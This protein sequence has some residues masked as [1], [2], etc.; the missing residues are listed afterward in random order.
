MERYEIHK[1]NVGAI[2]SQILMENFIV[3]TNLD[4]EKVNTQRKLSLKENVLH[5]IDKV[6]NL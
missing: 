5:A 4:L 1:K 3:V 6:I 2:V